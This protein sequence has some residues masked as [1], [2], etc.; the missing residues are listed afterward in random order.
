M[1]V[2][3]AFDMVEA[4][5]QQLQR[6]RRLMCA[7]LGGFPEAFAVGVSKLN[8]PTAGGRMQIAVKFNEF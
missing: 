1:K 8:A 2:V 3:R 4:M 7:C 6:T 5:V